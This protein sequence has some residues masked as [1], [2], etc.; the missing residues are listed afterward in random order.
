MA[1]RRRAS[2]SSRATG[3][4]SVHL[5][6]ARRILELHAGL[7]AVLGCPASI[8]PDRLE[9]ALACAYDASALGSGDCR[10]QA[11]LVLMGF[12]VHRPAGE[13]DPPLAFLAVAALFDAN[14]FTFDDV[15]YSEVVGRLGDLVELRPEQGEAEE[16]QRWLIDRSRP[17]AERAVPIPVAELRRL[18]DSR[19]LG[20]ETSEGQLRILKAGPVGDRGSWMSRM[21]RKPSRESVHAL[22]VPADGAIGFAALRD[23]LRASGLRAGTFL[24]DSAWQAGI[25]L[26][27]RHLWPRLRGLWR[28]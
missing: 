10:V 20:I 11:A 4:V 27:Y 8:D 13:L 26:Q 21:F 7:A 22:P 19:G 28:G 9:A 18:L 5:L 24:D 2:S 17:A 3:P 15:P 23:L 1:S 16:L 6:G 14:G 25:L 12:R